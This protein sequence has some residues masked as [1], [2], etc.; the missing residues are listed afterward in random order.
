MGDRPE[1]GEA[2]PQMIDP[3][4]DFNVSS[5][6]RYITA[7]IFVVEL[8]MRARFAGAKSKLGKVYGRQNEGSTCNSHKGSIN[9]ESGENTFAFDFNMY[10]LNAKE[11]RTDC[12]DNA[13]K[14]K[15]SPCHCRR[16]CNI[17]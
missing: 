15:K 14:H 17:V 2:I 5:V 11:R 8:L 12:L 7:I 6:S 3:G 13:D 10:S 4:D 1:A 9:M 16:W